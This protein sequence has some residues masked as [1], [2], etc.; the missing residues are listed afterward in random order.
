MLNLNLKRKLLLSVGMAL[1][2]VTLLLSGFAYRSLQEQVIDGS[3]QQISRLSAYSTNA[4]SV[5][6]KG[7]EDSL[8][9]LFNSGKYLDPETLALLC[10]SSDFVSIYHGDHQ[11][12]MV[13]D[14]PESDAEDYKDYKPQEEKWFKAGLG[15]SR[16]VL[17]TPY[18]D[19]TYTPAEIVLSV[20]QATPT[21]VLGGDITTQR[22]QQILAETHL[23]AKGFTIL[24][25]ETG[26][27]VAYQ[28]LKRV[29]KP[30]NE[31][32][33]GVDTSKITSLFKQ[34][35]PLEVSLDGETKLLWASPIANSNWALLSLVDK[36]T[37]L[38]PLRQQLLHQT[39]ISVIVLVISLLGIGA[40]ISLLIAP[41]RNVSTALAHISSG[42]GD[43]TQRIDVS[44]KDEVGELANNFNRFIGTLHTLI[45]GIRKEAVDMEH[46][47]RRGLAQ[48]D[49]SH[50]QVTRQEQEITQVATAVTQMASATQEI[51]Q[52]A[53]QTAA[54]AQSSSQSTQ[55]G[56]Q[57]VEK[58]RH[59]ITLLADEVEQATTVINELNQH[60][61]AISS[62]LTTIKSIAEQT[63]LLALN[64]AIE[65]AR[66]GDQGR[67]FAV[68]ADEVRVLSHRTHAST[69]EIQ[70]T[71]ATLQASTAS[72]VAMMQQSRNQ[73]EQ[74]VQDADAASSALGEITAAIEVIS[75]MSTQIATAAEEQHKVTDEITRNVHEI[76]ELADQLTQDAEEGA[77][78]AREQ[79]QLA[80][81]LNNQVSLFRL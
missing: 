62:V 10:Q 47:A 18:L 9:A 35:E 51:A 77:A 34:K 32:L 26:N 23:P 21:G 55:Q 46:C 19:E 60:A 56:G 65:A 30:L 24:V 79:Q 3:Y 25:D 58:T 31:L 42:D 20:V 5:W 54:A 70:G 45:S 76:K 41:L 4:I 11:G 39:I 28:D 44:S 75:D 78:Q 71:I 53:E 63:N 6:L 69:T 27:V 57:L 40:F 80:S 66:A 33:K 7:K 52:H 61:Q 43:L 13:D 38:A 64:A 2:G 15:Q 16:P 12:K 29:L 59:S 50:Q 8:A 48:A 1:I 81:S 67:G 37:L 14:D 36:S 74:S 22:V 68:V 49:N 17:T 72:A 73:A